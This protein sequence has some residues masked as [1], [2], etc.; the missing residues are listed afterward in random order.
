VP[1]PQVDT[2]PGRHDWPA[3]GLPIVFR[4][5]P[6]H[7]AVVKPEQLDEWERMTAENLGLAVTKSDVD[8]SASSW[9][10]TV[11]FCGNKPDGDPN[12]CDSD[13]LT[14]VKEA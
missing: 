12:P 11:S 6:T 4:R 1:D 7:Y 14:A 2:S 10:E 8:Y 3:N 5:P 9:L 13:V